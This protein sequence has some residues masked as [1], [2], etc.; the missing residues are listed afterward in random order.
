VLHIYIY[1]Y[2]YDISRLR[3]NDEVFLYFIISLIGP[4]LAQCMSS[5]FEGRSFRVLTDRHT[6]IPP[7]CLFIKYWRTLVV[8][9]RT[10]VSKHHHAT[11]TKARKLNIKPVGVG[12]HVY[13]PVE[14]DYKSSPCS[15]DNVMI[16]NGLALG[17][18]HIVELLNFPFCAHILHAHPR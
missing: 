15:S 11:R 2:I 7:L 14:L 1:I 12:A 10:A 5:N 9:N 8:A 4:L 13:Q 3:D 6:Q 16:L 18:S 17:L